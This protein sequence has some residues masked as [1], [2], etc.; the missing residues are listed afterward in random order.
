MGP[1]GEENAQEDLIH[2][3]KHLVG[4]HQE[5]ATRVFLVVPHERIRSNGHT[6]Y[7]VQE[8]LFEHKKNLF[9]REGGS[10]W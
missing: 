7:T 5:D 8:I 2:V 3:Y 6:K 4:R 1:S 10:T 9:Q